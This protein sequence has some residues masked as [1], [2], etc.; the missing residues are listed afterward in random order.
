MIQGMI[1]AWITTEFGVALPEFNV[2][3]AEG[4]VE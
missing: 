4:R 1:S 3:H 2:K